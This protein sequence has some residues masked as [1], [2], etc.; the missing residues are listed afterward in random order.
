MYFHLDNMIFSERIKM[1]H[2]NEEFLLQ[3]PISELS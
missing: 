2:F 3:W 1:Q